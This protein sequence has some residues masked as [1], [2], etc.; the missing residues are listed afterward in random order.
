MEIEIKLIKLLTYGAVLFLIFPLITGSIN[1]A[2]N[3]PQ[4]KF[5]YFLIILYCFAETISMYYFLHKWNNLIFIR[6]GAFLEFALLSLFYYKVITNRSARVFIVASFLI[7]IIVAIFD[8]IVHSSLKINDYA[9]SLEALLM[10]IYTVILFYQ[11]MLTSEGTMVN[12]PL[13]LINSAFLFYYSG[14]LFYFLFSSFL[15]DA[16]CKESKNAAII[17]PLMNMIYYIPISIGFWK[18][19]K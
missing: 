14:N 1:K 5:I 6:T 10:I 4:L 18:L 3:H 12:N 9:L 8:Y 16:A 17:L 11:L 7:Y 19:K 15:Y 13:F 2:Y